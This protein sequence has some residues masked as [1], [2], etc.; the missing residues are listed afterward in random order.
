[1]DMY[2]FL[3]LFILIYN[4]FHPGKFFFHVF[5]Q[6]KLCSAAIQIMSLSVNLEIMI[7]LQIVCEETHSTF[8]SHKDCSHGK[9]IQFC[10][11]QRTATAFNEAFDVNFIQMKITGHLRQI[12]LILC[13]GTCAKA[14]RITEIIYGKLKS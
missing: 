8:K 6:F 12:F 3:Y 4:L 13:S 11:S 14:D 9:H 10:L 1:M 7:S 2:V 5:H